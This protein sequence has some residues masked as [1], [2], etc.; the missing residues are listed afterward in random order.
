MACC[1]KRLSRISCAPILSAAE[2]TVR[3]R[4]KASARPPP[5]RC[6]AF[7]R[8]APCTSPGGG[9]SSTPPCGERAILDPRSPSSMSM[10]QHPRAYQSRL[11]SNR[12]TCAGLPS[13][14]PAGHQESVH[15]KARVPTPV[16]K[17]QRADCASSESHCSTAAPTNF[18]SPKSAS[19]ASRP[20]G[21]QQH[22]VNV[23]TFSGLRSRK[24]M[25]LLWRCSR[26][27]TMQEARCFASSAGKPSA[28]PCGRSRSKMSRFKSQSQSSS[29]MP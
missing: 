25:R 15:M 29:K 13:L 19:F 26:A 4:S 1:M 16:V 14:R 9:G 23:S 12:S 27:T 17:W 18:A 5:S 3:E 2:S 7:S 8:K 11:A 28:T 21:P 6:R 20:P 10:R 24:T 22:E